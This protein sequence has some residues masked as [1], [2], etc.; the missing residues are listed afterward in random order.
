MTRV[1]PKKPF[2]YY[3][4]HQVMVWNRDSPHYRQVG[5]IKHYQLVETVQNGKT[6]ISWNYVVDLSY[7][8]DILFVAFPGEDLA[9]P[10]FDL[11]DFTPVPGT[12]WYQITPWIFN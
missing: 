12:N 3:L 9:I 1:D 11:N 7:G 2:L 8:T 10:D 4:D 6:T 5:L